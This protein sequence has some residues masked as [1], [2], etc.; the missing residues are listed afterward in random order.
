MAKETNYPPLALFLASCLLMTGGWLMASFPIFIFLG[1]APLFA[2]TDRATSTTS[3][4]EKMEWVLLALS[5]SFLASRLFDLSH[6][7]ASIAFGILFTLPFIGYVWVKQTLG[8]QVGKISIVLFWLALEYI[9]LKVYAPNSIF[10]ADALRLQPVW[11][12]WN[13]HTGYLGASLWILIANL[14]VYYAFLSQNPFRWHWILLALIFI[15]TPFFSSYFLESAPIT[16]NDML[17]LYS[18][19]STTTN[20]MYLARGEF[21]VR[22]A[23]WVSTLI[24]LFTLIKSQTTK[25]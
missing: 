20:V 4:W 8:P 5:F 21:V 12:L 3:V 18:E 10:L 6:L 19:N 14:M 13:L 2:L 15:V 24:L 23:A 22:T 17:N 1:L 11:T 25:A 16:R 9:L 7:V